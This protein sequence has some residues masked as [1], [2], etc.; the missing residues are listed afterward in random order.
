LAG[1]AVG[2]YGGLEEVAAQWGEE[3][4]FTPTLPRDRAAERMA[5]WEQAVRQARA[6]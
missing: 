2:V 4:R 6:H 5:L 3:R 1:L